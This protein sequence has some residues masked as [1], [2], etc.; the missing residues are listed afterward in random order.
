MK[1]KNEEFAQNFKWGLE[2]IVSRVEN[3][4][5]FSFMEYSVVKNKLE[6]VDS[7]LN[8]I[9]YQI[10][11]GFDYFSI[12]ELKRRSHKN[13]FLYFNNQVKSAEVQVKNALNKNLTHFLKE[14][15]YRGK[16][17]G[18]KISFNSIFNKYSDLRR[19]Y[20]ELFD[21]VTRNISLYLYNQ[22]FSLIGFNSNPSVFES[23]LE[24]YELGVFPKKR[25][26]FDWYLDNINTNDNFVT[27]PDL[28]VVD[29]PI[30][31]RSIFSG[32]NLSCEGS[33]VHMDKGYYFFKDDGK[34]SWD[35]RYAEE[36]TFVFKESKAFNENFFGCYVQGEGDIFYGHKPRS[37]C[38]FLFPLEEDDWVEVL[39]KKR[40]E[41][42]M[43]LRRNF[44]R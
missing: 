30:K 7:I 5:D 21:S 34:R 41:S 2:C 38:D 15:I 14:E 23:F 31:G 32:V 22:A 16:D 18:N 44:I 24:L 43:S 6:K 19:C 36:S 25:R 8:N 33:I 17:F 35:M 4:N 3:M 28:F 39:N 9:E 37:T 12:S 10:E 11:D 29:I 40:S 1:K 26:S 20:G 42:V 13:S 27:K